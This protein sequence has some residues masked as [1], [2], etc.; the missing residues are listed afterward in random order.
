MNNETSNSFRRA[1]CTGSSKFPN[2]RDLRIAV[3][4]DAQCVK[5]RVS[6]PKTTGDIAI[7]LMPAIAFS[8]WPKRTDILSRIPLT[9]PDVLVHQQATTTVN[10][11]RADFSGRVCFD[12]FAFRFLGANSFRDRRRSI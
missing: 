12:P 4:E 9:H 10:V 6:V 5:L 3:V 7:V 1:G 2:P 11:F 8:S